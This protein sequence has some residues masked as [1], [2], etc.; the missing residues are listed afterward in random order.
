MMGK[1]GDKVVAIIAEY[2]RGK[3]QAT[4]CIPGQYGADL[5]DDQHTFHSKAL[6]LLQW[7]KRY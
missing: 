1:A 7:F 3:A 4:A 6:C 2:E 5:Q